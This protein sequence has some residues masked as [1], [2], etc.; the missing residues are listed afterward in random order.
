M[1]KARVPVITNVRLREPCKARLNSLAD[2]FGVTA[3]DLVREAIEQKLPEWERTG[4]I[5]MARKS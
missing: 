2:R 5:L 1:K 4:V 3:S